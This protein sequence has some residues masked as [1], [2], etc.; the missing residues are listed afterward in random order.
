MARTSRIRCKG[1]L[2]QSQR[3]MVAV[4]Y[5][6]L[7]LAGINVCILFKQCT[8]SR[9]ARRKVLQ[10]LAAELRAEY[11]EGKG[12]VADGT[13]YSSGSNHRSSSRHGDGGSAGLKVLQTEQNFRHLT[14]HKSVC[15]NCVV[16]LRAAASPPLVVPSPQLASALS[17][18]H[19]LLVTTI[20]PPNVLTALWTI[21]TLTINIKLLLFPFVLKYYRS[22]KK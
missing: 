2:H 11:L 10:Q 22:D 7:D 6:I 17:V 15:G 19:L 4:F 1:V 5:N 12:A 8:S 13:R 3:K 21:S 16:A 14:C 18:L 9:R 20:V